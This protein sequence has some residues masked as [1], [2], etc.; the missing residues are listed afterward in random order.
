MNRRNWLKISALLTAGAYTGTAYAMQTG[1]YFPVSDLPKDWLRLGSNENPYGCSP[2]VMEAMQTALKECNRYPNYDALIQ[3]IAAHHQVAAEQICITAGSSEALALAAIAFARNPSQNIVTAKPTFNVF[4]DVAERLGV[5]RI[6]IPLTAEK[7][8]D[9]NKMATAVNSQTAAVYVCNPNNPTGTKVETDA[10]HNFVQEIAKRTVVVIDEVYHDFIN[11]PSLIPKTT[12]NPNLVV[13][14]SFSKVY[15]LAGMRIGYAVAHADTVKKMQALIS[16]PGITIS[17]AGVAAA[18]A[19]LDDPAFVQMSV[20]KNKESQ[21]VLY[22][23]LNQAKIRYIPSYANLVYFSLDGFAPTY[24]KDMQA[25]KV[26]VREIDDYGQR[27]C[28][29]SMGTPEE[30]QQFVEILKTMRS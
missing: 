22:N 25:R 10:L 11:A 27:W 30:M 7:V 17:Q 21:Q 8:I 19:A 16:R 20:T 6:D 24:L 4:P 14:R 12:A 3:K 2:K 26:I 5:T 9:L 15:G 18:M 23:Y 28:R 29:V 1:C 13:I